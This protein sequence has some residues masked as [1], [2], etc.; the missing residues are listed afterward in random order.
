VLNAQ[1]KQTGSFQWDDHWP[2]GRRGPVKLAL[3]G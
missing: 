2:N 1:M 3:Q